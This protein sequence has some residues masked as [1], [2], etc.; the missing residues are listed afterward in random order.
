MLEELYVENLGIIQSAR[1]EPRAS[2]VRTVKEKFH[3]H[4]A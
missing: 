3:L 4:D 1:L 2:L